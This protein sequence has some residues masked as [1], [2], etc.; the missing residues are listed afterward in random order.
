M[1]GRLIPILP[2]RVFDFTGVAVG[3]TQQIVLAE[4]VDVSEFIDCMLVVHSF[5]VPAFVTM[6]IDVYGDGFTQEEPNMLF[7]TS[8][9]LFASTTINSA[10]YIFPYGG[11]VRGQFV[12][13]VLSANR[14]A[15]G[16]GS[17]W[18]AAAHMILRSPDN[19][20]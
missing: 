18:T 6:N 4:R 14:S 7:R 5:S 2:K 13:L 10:T 19:V 12:T 8:A 17:T 1:A 16:G 3:A 15:P 9:P 11:T 20:A